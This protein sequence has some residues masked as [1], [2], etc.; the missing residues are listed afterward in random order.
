MLAIRLRQLGDVL[1][2]LAALE[3]VKRTGGVERVAFVV[4]SHYH[5]LLRGLDYIDI[6]IPQPPPVKGAGGLIRFAQYIEGVRDLQAGCV[7]DFHSNPRS[8]LITAL[9]GAPVRIGFDVRVR[10]WVYTDVEPRAIYRNGVVLPRS[11][12]ESAL[13]LTLRM[14]VSGTASKQLPEIEPPEFLLSKGREAILSIG[15]GAGALE[16]RRVVGLNPGNPYVSKSWPDSYFV[17]LANELINRGH[18]VVVMWGP[19][20]MEKARS[21]QQ[22]CGRRAFLAPPLSLAALPAFLKNLALLVTI[23]SGLK[24][25][26]VC[27]RI[28]T[29][30]IFGPTSPFEWHMGGDRDVFLYRGISCSPCRLLQCPFGSPCMKEIKPGMVIEQIEPLLQQQRGVR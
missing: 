17:E 15:V 14:G 2:T 26:A 30:T 1:A 24:H 13:A 29:V 3:L 4:D 12:Q 22:R 20:E 10:K 21:I 25:L 8:A 6:L 9:S 23:D 18:E 27:A 7:L 16:T 19:G 28:A 5:E 11:S